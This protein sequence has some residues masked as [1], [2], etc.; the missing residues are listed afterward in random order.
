MTNNFIHLLYYI[1][2][3]YL[4]IIF[5]AT[6]STSVYLLI[7]RNI[8][9]KNYDGV[10]QNVHI[11]GHCFMSILRIHD[12]IQYSDRKSGEDIQESKT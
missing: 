4:K 6:T 8:T 2:N 9:V 7:L 10:P 1:L 12:Y 11:H 3:V 5:E